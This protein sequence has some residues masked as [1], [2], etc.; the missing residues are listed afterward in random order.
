MKLSEFYNLPV[1]LYRLYWKSGGSSIAA[2]GM[3]EKGLR[4]IA[5]VNWVNPATWEGDVKKAIRDISS[6]SLIEAQ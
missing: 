6:V 4:W 2:I 3:N 1:G 5:C